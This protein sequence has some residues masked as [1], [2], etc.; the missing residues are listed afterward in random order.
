MKGLVFRLRDGKV[1]Q[2]KETGKT[3]MVVGNWNHQG[4]HLPTSLAVSRRKKL[5]PEGWIWSGV[6]AITG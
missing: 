2:M 4:N 6:P 5:D 3:N 1:P